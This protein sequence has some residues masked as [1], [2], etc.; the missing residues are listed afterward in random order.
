MKKTDKPTNKNNKGNNNS[1]NPNNIANDDDN[2]NINVTD[3]PIT[4]DL[5]DLLLEEGT[6]D[7]YYTGAEYVD[8][9]ADPEDF[10]PPS[11]IA[12]LD[13]DNDNPDEIPIEE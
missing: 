2:N 5:S 9:D 11:D 4:D 7:S 1:S 10:E 12:D 8:P 13:L 3:E 6:D